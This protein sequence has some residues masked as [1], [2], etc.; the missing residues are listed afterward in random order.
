MRVFDS[1]WTGDQSIAGWLP[2]D[3]GSVAGYCV[4]REM[5]VLFKKL[6]YEAIEIYSLNITLQFKSY[7]NM[8]K[9]SF[10]K[11][12]IKRTM[13]ARGKRNDFLATSKL[14]IFSD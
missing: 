6:I 13:V 2:A 4:V 14:T 5:I 12:I 10:L 7:V 9:F 11:I 1:T 8:K 3:A